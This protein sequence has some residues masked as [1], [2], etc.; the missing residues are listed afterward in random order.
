MAR[1]LGRPLRPDES[2]HHINGIRWDNNLAN[3]QLR[4]GRHGNGVV[5]TCRAC[6][7]HDLSA[8]LLADFLAAHS[9]AV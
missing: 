1:S 5:L 2:V 3:L 4:Q 9:A 7:S 8:E 6:G